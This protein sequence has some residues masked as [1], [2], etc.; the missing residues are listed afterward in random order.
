MENAT[1]F[2]CNIAFRKAIL[3]FTLSLL[4]KAQF[5]WPQKLVQY[6]LNN[7]FLT[8]QSIWSKKA[9]KYIC[10]KLTN[11]I[12]NDW[13]YHVFTL[14]IV[15][16]YQFHFVLCNT[17]QCVWRPFLAKMLLSKWSIDRKCR[18]SLC[19]QHRSQ[20]KPTPK[21]HK[22]NKEKYGTNK[23]KSGTNHISDLCHVNYHPYHIYTCISVCHLDHGTFCTK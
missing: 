1:I 11:K 7:V 9:I 21:N 15:I 4:Y 20:F 17:L 2:W 19:C 22:D 10:I 13:L 3:I 14:W 16:S 8:S 18:V 5:W 12:F 6:R 23:E